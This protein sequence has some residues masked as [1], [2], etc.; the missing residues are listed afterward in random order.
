MKPCTNGYQ[1][2]NVSKDVRNALGNVAAT[3]NHDGMTYGEIAKVFVRSG[4]PVSPSTVGVWVGHVDEGE[5]PLKRTTNAGK[6]PSLTTEEQETLA[7]WVLARED[8]AKGTDLKMYLQAAR[9]LFDIELSKPT[10]SRYLASAG[11]SYKLTGSRPAKEQKSKDKLVDEALEWYLGYHNDGFGAGEPQKLWC[12]DCVTDTEKNMRN[13]TFG[14]TGGT[15]RKI[16]QG[17]RIFTSS[18]YASCNAVGQQ[19][20]PGVFSN[21]PD[22]DPQGPNGGNVRKCAKTKGLDPA[23]LYYIPSAKTYCKEDRDS[24]YSFLNATKPWKGHRILSDKST[25]FRVDGEDFFE[26]LGFEQHRTFPPDVHGPMSLQDGF[27]NSWAKA[28]WRS[29]CSPQMLQWEKTLLLAHELLHIPPAKTSA[30][31]EE[32]MLVGATPTRD[33]VEHFLFPKEHKNAE[34]KKMWDRCLATYYDLDLDDGWDDTL[35][36]PAALPS[37]L[38]GPFWDK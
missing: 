22:F 23:F 19:V 1:A 25:I 10:A 3:L 14:R 38:N 31:W 36:A 35:D 15:Q 32:H 9:R 5:P 17:P 4:A 21:N 28:A 7:G 2:T 16:Q 24:Y 26:S 20:G 27:M 37:G 18:L 8:D 29:S 30:A 12:I 13:K 6:K 33:K 34:R 11:L